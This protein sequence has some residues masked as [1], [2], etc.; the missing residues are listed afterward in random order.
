M[1]LHVKHFQFIELTHINTYILKALESSGSNPLPE[2]LMI[3]I[4]HLIDNRIVIV[5]VLVA[6]TGGTYN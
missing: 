4:A 1:I 6:L 2:T 3:M 5:I